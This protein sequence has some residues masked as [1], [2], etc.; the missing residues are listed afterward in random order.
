MIDGLG[1]MKEE[2]AWLKALLL[3]E[4]RRDL[5]DELTGTARRR[6]L[7]EAEKDE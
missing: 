6:D 3:R 2:A 5:T 4:E 7:S 1:K